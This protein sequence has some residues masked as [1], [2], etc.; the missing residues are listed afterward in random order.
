MVCYSF[1]SLVSDVF[2]ANNLATPRPEGTSPADVTSFHSGQ[3]LWSLDNLPPI[4]Y[5]LEPSEA[6]RK[7]ARSAIPEKKRDVRGQIVFEPF[8]VAGKVRRPMLDFKILV[9]P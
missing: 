5:V 4:Y 8:P 2:G 3:R 6:W 1:L 9:C 7:F